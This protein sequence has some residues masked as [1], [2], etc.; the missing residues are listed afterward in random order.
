M[1]TQ[2]VTEQ[3]S[4][5]PAP[6][7]SEPQASS[8]PRQ[9]ASDEER[10]EAFG[11][12]MDEIR[13]R[14]E[15]KIGA[16]DVDYIKKVRRF[17]TAM[18]VIGRGLIHFSF[19]PVTFLAGVGALWLHRQLESTEIGHTALHGAFDGLPGAE[20]F[21]SKKFWWDTPIDE[22]SWRYAHNV[23]HHQYTN[24]VGKDPDVRFGPVR[25]NPAV[26][27]NESHQNQIRNTIFSWLSFGAGINAHVTGLAD[28]FDTSRKGPED[29]DHIEKRDLKTLA[30]GLRKALRKWIPYY[31]KEYVLFPL[32]AGPFFWKVALGN[33][34]AQT[35]A[36][37][38]SAATIYCGHIGEDVKDYAAGTRA[39]GRGEWYA[40]QV[41]GASNFEVPLPV[42]QLCGALD[43]QIEHHLFPK[44]P[45][46]RL[47]EVSSEV[48]RVC[49]EHGV[50]YRTGT[51]G[52][53][54]Q[55]VYRRLTDLSKPDARPMPKL[56]EVV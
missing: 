24:I 26:P 18:E 14:T 10:L 56:G 37:V 19:E 12:A 7:Q 49:E 23:R 44:F 2:T 39:R 22:A 36:D 11:K 5:I 50:A 17:S 32:L 47:R 8:R 30:T 51:W 43:R 6:T 46:N 55:E 20:K 3:P 34:L 38:Y 53:R 15:A 16:E 1:E 9:W 25:L 13:K 41:E 40:M 27:Y 29:F 48:K 33:F 42:S 45:T 4:F 31:A 35:I 54:L 28:F 21:D 52:E